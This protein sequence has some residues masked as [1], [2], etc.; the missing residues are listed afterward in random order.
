MCFIS[1]QFLNKG[2]NGY[3]SDDFNKNFLSIWFRLGLEWFLVTASL[4][5]LRVVDSMETGY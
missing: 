4:T 5:D 2:N 3:F 1:Q